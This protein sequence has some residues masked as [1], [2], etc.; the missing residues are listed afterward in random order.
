M[1]AFSSMNFRRGST[2]SPIN[3]EK[4][5]SASYGVLDLHLQQRAGVGI[6]RGLPQLLG[7]HLSKAF[8][9]L[10]VQA[11]ARLRDHVLDRCVQRA[12]FDRFLAV[13]DDERRLAGGA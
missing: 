7:V 8:V 6:H 4:I 2:S 9:A 13:N 3:V 1:S 11:L 10:D 12:R 5:S